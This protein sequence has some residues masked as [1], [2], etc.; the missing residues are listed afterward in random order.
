MK[1]GDIIQFMNEEL[2]TVFTAVIAAATCA[3]TVITIK[4]WKA[5][6]AS[7]DV[8]KAT[9]LMNYL[10]TIAQESEKMRESNPQAAAFLQQITILVTEAAM[11]QFLSDIDLKKQPQVRDALNKFD[12]LLRA[13]NVDPQN[14]P[15][16]R[17]IAEKMKGAK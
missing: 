3:Y 16:F 14:I 9:V 17:P 10:A 15:W 4:L 11:E 6:M 13:Q 5:T 2:M 1:T 7:V 12:G 8:A